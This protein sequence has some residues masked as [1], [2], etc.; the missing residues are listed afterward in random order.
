MYIYFRFILKMLVFYGLI[1][2]R[3]QKALCV[4]KPFHRNAYNLPAIRST[5][6]ITA[7]LKYCPEKGGEMKNSTIAC[8]YPSDYLLTTPFLKGRFC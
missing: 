2:I 1:S 7:S 6:V 5:A 4:K 3:A 8:V